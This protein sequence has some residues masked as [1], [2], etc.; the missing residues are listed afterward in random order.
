MFVGV[1]VA[2]VHDHIDDKR[3]FNLRQLEVVVILE[4]AAAIKA[5]EVFVSGSLSFDR[6]WDR[7]PSVAAEPAAIE[8]Y[9]TARGRVPRCR[10]GMGAPPIRAGRDHGAHR[11][12]GGSHG[13]LRADVAARPV[14]LA[15]SV[16]AAADHS[17]YRSNGC[18]HAAGGDQCRHRQLWQRREA[19]CVTGHLSGQQRECG[20]AQERQNPQRQCMGQALVV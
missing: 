15:A 4:P 3:I 5:G 20:K 2:L 17:R 14:C 13:P 16:D 7:L 10:P 11:R 18:G 19:G 12:T 8:A 6:F 1:K 9:A